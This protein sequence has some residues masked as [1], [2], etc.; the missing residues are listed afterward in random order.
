MAVS[1]GSFVARRSPDGGR[2]TSISAV[3]P[4]VQDGRLRV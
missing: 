1:A 3:M 2:L 4:Q